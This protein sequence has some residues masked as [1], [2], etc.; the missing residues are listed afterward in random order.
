LAGQS[1]E[2]LYA[3]TAAD[4]KVLLGVRGQPTFRHHYYWPRAIPQYN[5]GY[6]HYRN[7]MTTIEQQAPGLF[8]AGHIRDGISLGDSIV[9]GINIVER[10]SAL[11]NA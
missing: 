2:D 4:L 5:L 11:W 9:S 6:G 1:P 3:L 7:L 10:V 8:F